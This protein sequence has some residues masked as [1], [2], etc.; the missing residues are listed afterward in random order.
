[1][2][3]TATEDGTRVDVEHRGFETVIDGEA[4]RTGYEAGWE[5]VL[6]RYAGAIA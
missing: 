5:L 3:F 4:M 2:R 1:M 6:A